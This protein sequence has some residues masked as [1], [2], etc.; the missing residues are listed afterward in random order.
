MVMDDLFALGTLVVS[1]SRLTTMMTQ[2]LNRPD[3]SAA[4]LGRDIRD[5]NVLRGMFLEDLWPGLTWVRSHVRP[6]ELVVYADRVPIRFLWDDRLDNRVAYA[7]GASW[8]DLPAGLDENICERARGLDPD[9]VFSSNGDG[10]PAASRSSRGTIAPTSR[11]I[12]SGSEAPR[13]PRAMRA[14]T[15]LSASASSSAGRHRGRVWC[16]NEKSCWNSD[17]GPPA[18]ERGDRVER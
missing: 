12:S 8:Q 10:A 16:R 15:N 2:L 5:F 18:S 7:G 3:G 1:P 11:T 14:G 13:L 9:Y 4:E 17:A 6:G